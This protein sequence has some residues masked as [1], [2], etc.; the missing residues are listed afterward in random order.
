M[1]KL[2]ALILCCVLLTGLLAA[3]GSAGGK[4]PPFVSEVDPSATEVPAEAAAEAGGINYKGLCTRTVTLDDVKAAEGRDP[5]FEFPMGDVTAYA[6]NN[7]MLGE[8][9]FTQVQFSFTEKNVR[10]SCTADVET[11]VDEKLNE[12]K[13][14]LIA[15]YG[16][17]SE[18]NS[19]W[20]WHEDSGNY[21][22][23]TAINDTTAQLVFYLCAE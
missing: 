11:G 10:I 7:V 20:S 6:Y 22:M 14:V 8:L 16:E 2:L 4:A 1:K 9:S 23:L 13:E 21:I 5:D 3:C 18:G 17:P 19:T 15:Q 12:W